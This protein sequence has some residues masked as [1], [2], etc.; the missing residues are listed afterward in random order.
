MVRNPTGFSVLAVLHLIVAAPR[1]VRSFELTIE[2]RQYP[3][4]SF[5]SK[6]T[7]GFYPT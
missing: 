5:A 4:A 1:P 7:S 6:V 3:N 2:I